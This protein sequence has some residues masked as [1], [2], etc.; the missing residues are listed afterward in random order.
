MQG[1][2]WWGMN[3]IGYPVNEIAYFYPPK[4]E[5]EGWGTRLGVG[6]VRVKSRVLVL[7][8]TTATFPV[9]SSNPQFRRP[10]RAEVSWQQKQW[11]PRGEALPIIAK[12]SQWMTTRSG[13]GHKT[14]IQTIWDFGKVLTVSLVFHGVEFVI[15]DYVLLL[16]PWCN[17]R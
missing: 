4:S 14:E 2:L 13:R 16:S 3:S 7:H 6:R 5:R 15:L 11:D 9:S 17:M 12:T 8:D 10:C 1:R